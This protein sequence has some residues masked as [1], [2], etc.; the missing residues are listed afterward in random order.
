MIGILAKFF[1]EYIS[2]SESRPLRRGLNQRAFV[3]TWLG[4]IAFVAT[5]SVLLFYL[6]VKMYTF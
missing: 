4:L 2:S 6:T 1:V 5:F 3:L